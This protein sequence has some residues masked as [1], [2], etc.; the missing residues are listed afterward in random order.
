MHGVCLQHLR[1]GD[2]IGAEA[3]LPGWLL[4]WYREHMDRLDDLDNFVVVCLQPLLQLGKFG[5]ELL[6]GGERLTQSQEGAKPVDAHLYR[7]RGVEYAGSH[8]GSVF[9]EGIGRVAAASTAAL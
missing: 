8:D 3:D 4:R 7:T 9:G 1:L 2:R 5:G 6:V